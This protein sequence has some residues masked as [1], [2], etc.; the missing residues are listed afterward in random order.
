MKKLAQTLGLCL[1]RTLLRY[2]AKELCV[3]SLGCRSRKRNLQEPDS[4]C[5]LFRSRCL[6]RRR[7]LLHDFIQFQLLARFADPSFQR[8]SQLD[9]HRCCRS[10]RPLSYRNSRTPRTWQSRVAPPSVIITE[11]STSSGEIPIKAHSW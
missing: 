11:S 1:F 8:L 2:G 9:D 6:S 5:R 3:R 4:L 7:R 10:L